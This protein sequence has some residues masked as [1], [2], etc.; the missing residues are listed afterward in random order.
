MK[1][2]FPNDWTYDASNEKMGNFWLIYPNYYHY[3]KTK[4]VIHHT[5]MDYDT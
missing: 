4:I 5:A 3:N 2:F 1:R